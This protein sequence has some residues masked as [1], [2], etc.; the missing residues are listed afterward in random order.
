MVLRLVDEG[1]AHM[2]VVAS[3]AVLVCYRCVIAQ[4]GAVIVPKNSHNG[5]A[6]IAS[7]DVY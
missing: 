6:A 2:Q 3:F 1:D 4:P 7:A 5:L